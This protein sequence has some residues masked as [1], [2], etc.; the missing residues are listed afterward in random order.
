MGPRI[1]GKTG[2]LDGLEDPVGGLPLH[3]LAAHFAQGVEAG[4]Q[5]AGWQVGE[6]AGDGHGNVG[7]HLTLLD[8]RHAAPAGDQGVGGQHH[9][10]RVAPQH[11]QIVGVVG[12]AGGDG[13]LQFAPPLQQ[14][15]PGAPLMAT[16]AV[17]HRD[18]AKSRWHDD[19]TIPNLNLG[20]TPLGEAS[21][22]DGLEAGTT[23]SQPGH[24][25]DELLP[26]AQGDL[27]GI[28]RRL[29][30]SDRLGGF[31][32]GAM[33]GD[34]L[35]TAVDAD[36]VEIGEVVEHH[37]VGA[38]A[39]GNQPQIVALQPDGG[40][41]GGHPQHVGHRQPQLCQQLDQ[42]N[43]APLLQQ[44]V[45][46]HIVGT[47]GDLG[48]EVG[49][50]FQRCDDLRQ[51]IGV[52]AAQLQGEPGPQL[53]QR[54]GS[55]G[56]F[57]IRAD[58]GGQIGLQPVTTQAPG[59]S[60]N[61]GIALQTG[62]QDAGHPLAAAQ[63][64]LHVHHLGDPRHLRPLQH[65]GH[66]G[67]V[68]VGARHL[69][70]WCRGNAGRR[71]ADDPQRQIAAGVDGIAHPRQPEHIG[72]LVGIPEDGGGAL[73]DH[74]I[75]VA[76]RRQVGALHMDMAVDKTGREI[77]AGQIVGLACLLEGA[78]RMDAGD[79]R[80]DQPH[81]DGADL[82]GHHVDQVGVGQQQI[83]GGFAEGCLH[84]AAAQVE[85]CILFTHEGDGLTRGIMGPL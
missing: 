35:A 77:G 8:D 23:R 41:E 24:P 20:F 68:E 44:H 36:R 27:H 52:G 83:E 9:L 76:L 14:R 51:Q 53:F 38:A 32:N 47:E 60:L 48:G 39:G 12:V 7:Q 45:G 54:I 50:L 5:L 34:P 57:V 61:Q 56:E 31:E 72:Q 30:T 26:R 3:H 18:E 40:I 55:R 1:A 4:G 49:Q 80:A 59:V 6:H 85:G 2:P 84:G 15:Q 64:P 69:E 29:T 16:M 62:V 17:L 58:S 22:L 79:Q 10:L 33:A 46:R 42:R 70:T 13:P 28:A 25:D 73:R 81:V 65:G 11:H 66:L 21:P 67:A 75:G 37:Q 74:H 43:H 78:D 63:H 19:L 71:G 82:A